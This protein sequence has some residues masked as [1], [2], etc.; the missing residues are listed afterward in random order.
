M[1]WSEGATLL[2]GG[3]CLMSSCVWCGEWTVHCSLSTFHTSFLGVGVKS[4]SSQVP[5]V[6]PKEF[7]IAPHFSPICFG[8]SCSPFTYIVRPKGRNSVNKHRTL[9]FWEAPKFPFCEWSSNQ[10]GSLQNKQGVCRTVAFSFT[11]KSIL[12]YYTLYWI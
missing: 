6:F 11:L 9:H 7:G 12:S 3:G 2:G 5:D 1:S 8:K 4:K 10:I